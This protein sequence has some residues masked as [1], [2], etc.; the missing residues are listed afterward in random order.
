M[1]LELQ[2]NTAM[3]NIT[4]AT[5]FL[6]KDK[7]CQIHISL[8]N[9]RGITS[10]SLTGITHGSD[11]KTIIALAKLTCISFILWGSSLTFCYPSSLL[12]QV[13]KCPGSDE[14]AKQA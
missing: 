8:Q 7:D 9:Q 3:A 2:C 10:F 12:A 6:H 14:R 11:Q 13:P 4:A 5:R 1:H